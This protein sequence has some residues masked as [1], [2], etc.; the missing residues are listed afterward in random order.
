MIAERQGH[1][2][3][4]QMQ[5]LNWTSSSIRTV[6]LIPVDHFRNVSNVNLQNN[7]L[8]SFSGLIY[9]P[10]VKARGFRAVF[11]LKDFSTVLTFTHIKTYFLIKLSKLF[12]KLYFILFFTDRENLSLAFQI[13]LVN[14]SYVLYLHA[15]L[16]LQ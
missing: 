9:L 6:D 12:P 2:N 11:T 7:N 15:D 4:V 13:F 8:T 1:S 14:L 5:E 16:T 10:N 3:F